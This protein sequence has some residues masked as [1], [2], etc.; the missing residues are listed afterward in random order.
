MIHVTCM[1]TAENRDQLRNHTLGN[2]VWATFT[3]L[4]KKSYFK[5]ALGLQVYNVRTRGLKVIKTMLIKIKV[6]FQ[7][8]FDGQNEQ[9]H[10]ASSTSYACWSKII[11]ISLVNVIKEC[12]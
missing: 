4:N 8:A 5:D 1:L 2:R 12:Y 7:T 11:L 9:V 10:S 6:S 3:F